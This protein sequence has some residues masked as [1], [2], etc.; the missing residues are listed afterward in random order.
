MLKDSRVNA[1]SLNQGKLS[2]FHMA[3][4]GGN[5]KVCELFLESGA[6][7]T[8][9]AIGDNSPLHIATWHGHEEICQLII[10]TGNR[11]VTIAIMTDGNLPV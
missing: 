8:S 3:C 1:S 11:F 7:I 4:L 6:D 2:S 10:E 5:R 9:K